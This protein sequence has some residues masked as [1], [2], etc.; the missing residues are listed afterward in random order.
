[1][2]RDLTGT[3]AEHYYGWTLDIAE[4]EIGLPS[5]PFVPAN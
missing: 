2:I 3:R 5:I 4:G 1:M